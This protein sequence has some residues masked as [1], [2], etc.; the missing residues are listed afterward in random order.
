[1]KIDV[2]VH[3][4]KIFLPLF[5]NIFADHPNSRFSKTVNWWFIIEIQPGTRKNTSKNYHRMTLNVNPKWRQNMRIPWKFDISSHFSKIIFKSGQK[6]HFSRLFLS[7]FKNI[8]QIMRTAQNYPAHFSKIFLKSDENGRK[9][10]TF[11]KY[12]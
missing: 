6:A 4:S 10:S 8:C 3:F 9:R 1:M 11:Q 12:F 5:K 7:L 2:S